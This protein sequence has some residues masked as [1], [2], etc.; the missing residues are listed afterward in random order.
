MINGNKNEGK[1]SPLNNENKNNIHF[2][3][4]FPNFSA[5]KQLETLQTS[6]RRTITRVWKKKRK[7]AHRTV[8]AVP[9]DRKRENSG[10][11][12]GR[13]SRRLT[14]NALFDYA[15]DKAS[16]LI[17]VDSHRFGSNHLPL[18]RP[19]GTAAFAAAAALVLLHGKL[20]S[21]WLRELRT[22]NLA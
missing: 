17:F 20:F 16:A 6:Q 9:C 4:H 1:K 15:A 5:S 14:G 12:S 22:P 11:R 10:L 13:G 3:F 7:K 21:T 19:L 8:R 2:F 18:R